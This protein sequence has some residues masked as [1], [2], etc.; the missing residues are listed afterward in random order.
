MAFGDARQKDTRQLK[1]GGRSQTIR[2][3][4]PHPGIMSEAASTKSETASGPAQERGQDQESAQDQELRL[5]YFLSAGRAEPIRWILALKRVN[6]ED[7]RIDKSTQWKDFKPGVC[8][9]GRPLVTR[10]RS[11]R[12]I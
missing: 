7:H 1:T 5:L 8:E 6:Y 2:N 12:R 10:E 3:R 11:H 9:G 4:S